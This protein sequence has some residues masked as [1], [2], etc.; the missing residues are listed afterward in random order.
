MTNRTIEQWLNFYKAKTG[1]EDLRL[2]E[3]E[4]VFFHPEH[5]FLTGFTHGDILEIHHLCGDGKYWQGFIKNVIATN[6]N[7]K[8]IRAFT[9]RNPQA[10]I[11][12]YGGKIRGYYMEAE[13]NELK[14]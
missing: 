14:E 7:V 3:D 10:W 11:K 5:G 1:C 9:R 13:I 8:T 12:R 6:C 2:D 4:A